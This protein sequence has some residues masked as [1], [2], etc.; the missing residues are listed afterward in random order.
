M[1]LHRH[2]H[3][4]RRE[5]RR[6]LQ[7]VGT[8]GA[9]G[10]DSGFVANL[11]VRLAAEAAVRHR[12]A[13]VAPAT[14]RRR[15][16]PM[17]VLTSAAA[18]LAGLVLVG[19]LD[20]WF[21]QADGDV[22]LALAGAVDT[23]VVLP[24]GRSVEGHSGLVLPDGSVVRT[25]PN[26]RAA[27]GRVELGPGLEAQVDAGRLRLRTVPGGAP[28]TP[29]VDVSVPVSTPSGT[30]DTSTTGPPVTTT[31]LPLLNVRPPTETVLQLPGQRSR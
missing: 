17:P 21:G 16:R 1:R 24:D 19:A 8:R 26:G 4:S 10:P 23:T 14:R 13:L 25:G 5:L 22:A 27:A 18:V 7:D 29:G 30:G 20:G 3:P 12:I 15:V 31:T 6:E 9:P 11:A 28:A 2:A